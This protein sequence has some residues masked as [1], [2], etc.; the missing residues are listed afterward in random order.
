VDAINEDVFDRIFERL[1]RSGSFPASLK[2]PVLRNLCLKLGANCAPASRRIFSALYVIRSSKARSRR[3]IK[4]LTAARLYFAK[5]GVAEAV[6][7]NINEM[8]DS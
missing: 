5:Q 2:P 3:S 8:K 6:R 7:P 4:S 1:V